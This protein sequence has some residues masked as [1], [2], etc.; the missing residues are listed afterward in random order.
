MSTAT[1]VRCVLH[2]TSICPYGSTGWSYPVYTSERVQDRRSTFMAHAS[3][4]TDAS[5]LPHFLDHLNT[6]ARTKKA[7]HCTYAYRIVRAPDAAAELGQHDGGENGS[8]ERLSRLLDMSSCKNVIVVVWRWYGGVQLGADRWK[9]ISEVAKD[10]LTQG[11]FLS[12]RR[13][14]SGKSRK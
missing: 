11:G 8:G 9:R 12:G 6:I 14:A 3:T 2:L 1:S 4:F 7:T 10:A 5:T 13:K